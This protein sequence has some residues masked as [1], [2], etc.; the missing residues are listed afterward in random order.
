MNARIVGM[1]RVL[2]HLVERIE[3]AARRALAEVDLGQ[4]FPAG[5]APN[6]AFIDGNKQIYLQY[7]R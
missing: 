3:S 5:M 7:T 4:A 2:Q 6:L 1:E